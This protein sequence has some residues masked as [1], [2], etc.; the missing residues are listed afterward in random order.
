MMFVY[1]IAVLKVLLVWCKRATYTDPLLEWFWCILAFH[2]YKNAYFEIMAIEFQ[3]HRY[4]YAPAEEF[5][6]DPRTSISE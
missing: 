4:F 2:S 6:S 3:S 1:H 5:T